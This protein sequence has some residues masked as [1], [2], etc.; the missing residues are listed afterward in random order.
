LRQMP[1]QELAAS[2]TAEDQ[3]FDPFRFRHQ[4]SPCLTLMTNG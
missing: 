4:L 2:S 3:D 1:S